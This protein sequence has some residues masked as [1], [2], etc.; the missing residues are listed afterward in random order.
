ME[1]ARLDEEQRKI[2]ELIAEEAMEMAETDRE[3]AMIRVD[4]MKRNQVLCTVHVSAI[5]YNL[6]TA[7]DARG[8]GGAAQ[9]GGGCGRAHAVGDG[10]RG[11]PPGLQVFAAVQQQGG[12][13]RAHPLQRQGH[14]GVQDWAQQLG[15]PHCAWSTLEMCCDVYQTCLDRVV[16]PM[17]AYRSTPPSA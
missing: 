2:D 16:V 5:T 12:A 10:P 11:H 13:A 8:V 7:L 15:R 4:E 14:A 9:R 17:Y 6:C 1:R 3:K